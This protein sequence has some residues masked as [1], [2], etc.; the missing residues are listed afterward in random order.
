MNNHNVCSAFDDNT[1][2]LTRIRKNC[3]IISLNVNSFRVWFFLIRTAQDEHPRLG[4]LVG[5]ADLLPSSDR[6]PEV[7]GRVRGGCAG[8]P[9][10][11]DSGPSGRGLT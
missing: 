11:R 5:T 10:A 2:T 1:T 9:D 8:G 4:Q 6:R 7:R 3:I